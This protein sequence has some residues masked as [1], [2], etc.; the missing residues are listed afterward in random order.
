MFRATAAR[1]DRNLNNFTCTD[2]L[3]PTVEIILERGIVVLISIIVEDFHSF[4]EG[5][6]VK[7]YGHLA[8]LTVSHH[9]AEPGLNELGISC[10]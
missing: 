1:I 2:H 10:L 7:D 6:F 9:V 8:L 3:V 4:G 5:A